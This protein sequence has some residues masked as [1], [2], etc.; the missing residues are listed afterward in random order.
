MTLLQTPDGMIRKKHWRVLLEV[1]NK[2]FYNMKVAYKLTED[3]LDPKY[4][5]KMNV[6]MAFYVRISGSDIYE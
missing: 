5:Q 1:E 6:P 2:H 4:Y 3:H